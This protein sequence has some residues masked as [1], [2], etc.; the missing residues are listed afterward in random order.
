M[1]ADF[2]LSCE[3]TVDLPFSYVS[4]RNIPVLFYTYSIDGVPYVDD[5]LRDP[6]AL[7]RFYQL[8]DQGCTNLAA[9][10]NDNFESLFHRDFFSE[11]KRTPFFL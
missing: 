4:G 6:A 3:S 5:M 2:I 11:H 8:L 7:P 1:A 10:D 9:A